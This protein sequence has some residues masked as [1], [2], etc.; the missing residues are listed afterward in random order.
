MSF[1]FE[2][3]NSLQIAE[4]S[5]QLKTARSPLEM[6]ALGIN[7]SLIVE[8]AKLG[9]QVSGVLGCIHSQRLGDDQE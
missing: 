6:L 9:H 5:I 3:Y 8:G 1:V 7:L 2:M 4:S